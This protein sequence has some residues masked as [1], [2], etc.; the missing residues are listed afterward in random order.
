MTMRERWAMFRREVWPILMP[1]LV[2]AAAVAT[3]V[4]FWLLIP[5]LHDLKQQADMGAK[6]RVRQ[7]VVAKPA[8]HLYADAQKRG[9][10]TRRDL[11]KFRAGVPARCLK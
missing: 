1:G 10:I 9:V 2:I 11:E 6:A 8:D 4:N 7:C 3:S 5:A